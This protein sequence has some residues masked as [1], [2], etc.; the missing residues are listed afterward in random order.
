MKGND[1]IPEMKAPIWFLTVSLIITYLLIYTISFAVQKDNIP[2]K[3]EPTHP[4]YCN[5]ECFR[6]GSRGCSV[7]GEPAEDKDKREKEF[8]KKLIEH[9]KALNFK[10]QAEDQAINRLINK[11]DNDKQTNAVNRLRSKSDDTELQ[12]YNWL[13]NAWTLEEKRLVRCRLKKINNNKIKKW[14]ANNVKLKR[15]VHG[16]STPQWRA[17]GDSDLICE[18]QGV[19]TFKD[20]F[21][22][23]IITNAK[24]ENLVAFEIGKT[25]YGINKKSLRWFEDYQSTYG[26]IIDDMKKDLEKTRDERDIGLADVPDYDSRFGYVFRVC[27]FSIKKQEWKEAVN[28]FKMRLKELIDIDN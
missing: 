16:T 11:L 4:C 22:W 14:I 1:N 9:I 6:C 18:N 27:A 13:G 26:I 28:V 17:W 19:I 8:I 20:G 12:K 2:G 21:F 3:C 10:K 15:D 25:Y 5:D 23:D 24:R 7:P